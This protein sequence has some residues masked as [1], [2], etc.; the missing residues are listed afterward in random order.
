[1]TPAR[2]TIGSLRKVSAMA[3]AIGWKAALRWAWF[4]AMRNHDFEV[5]RARGNGVGA[6]LPGFALTEGDA[7]RVARLAQHP[8]FRVGEAHVAEYMR[9]GRCLVGELDGVPVHLMWVFRH[10]DA[11]RFFNLEPGD[12]ELN[13]CYTPPR[14][15]GR[16]VYREALRAAVRKLTG[17]GVKRVYVATHAQN[18][19]ARR[20]IAG[21]GFEPLGMLHHVGI[22]RRPKWSGEERPSL[23]K[24]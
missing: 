24:A 5:F 13:Y 1:M 21:A 23:G 14:W 7:A 15:R 19:P 4:G 10:G 17:E 2:R 16:G 6:A 11:S 12:A 3:G 22:F 20:A 9:C 18:L 8:D